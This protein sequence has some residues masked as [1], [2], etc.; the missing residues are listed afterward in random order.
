MRKIFIIV[1]ALFVI[2]ASIG[3]LCNRQKVDLLI[4][5]N[6]EVLSDPEIIVGPLCM[7]CPNYACSSLGEVFEGHY[8]A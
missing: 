4:Y 2:G 3:L 7:Q 1:G 5:K 8:P 6:I